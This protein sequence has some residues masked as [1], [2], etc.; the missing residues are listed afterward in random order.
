MA[1]ISSFGALPDPRLIIPAGNSKVP[2][3]TKN[4]NDTQPSAPAATDQT[5]RSP[6]QAQLSRLN[7]VLNSLQTNAISTRAQYVQALSKFRAGTYNV[8]SLTVSRF[9]VSDLLKN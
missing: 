1:Q 2:S 5:E 4:T 3:N 9:M 6:L 8:D 7:S